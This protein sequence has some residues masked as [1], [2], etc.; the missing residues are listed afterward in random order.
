[1]AEQLALPA[2]DTAAQIAADVPRP[3]G[4]ADPVRQPLA[5]SAEAASIDYSLYSPE[6]LQRIA[7]EA[8]RSA[9]A[10]RRTRENLPKQFGENP[11]RQPSLHE[12]IIE[13]G[14]EER[15]KHLWDR[16]KQGYAGEMQK[17]V[18]AGSTDLK[19]NDA[20][21]THVGYT[22]MQAENVWRETRAEFLRNNAGT[23][24]EEE[25]R[26]AADRAADEAEA[27][28]RQARRREY[29]AKFV[30]PRSEAANGDQDDE[31]RPDA[32]RATAQVPERTSTEQQESGRDSA[33]K[34][35]E[36]RTEEIS[37]PSVAD[38]AKQL[39]EST[40]RQTVGNPR[41]QTVAEAATGGQ[42]GKGKF[43]K[44][45]LVKFLI[46]A[47]AGA[48]TRLALQGVEIL[49]IPFL[50]NV[51]GGLAGAAASI[52]VEASFGGWRRRDLGEQRETK[53]QLTRRFL[54]AGLRGFGAGLV[55]AL[56]IDGLDR[57][58][59]GDSVVSGAAIDP[60]AGLEPGDSA[61]EGGAD[62]PNIGKHDAGAESLLTPELKNQVATAMTTGDFTPLVGEG[63]L[64]AGVENPFAQAHGLAEQIGNAGQQ[65]QWA[66]MMQSLN[67]TDQQLVEMFHGDT[68]DKLQAAGVQIELAGDVNG[69]DITGDVY[70]VES[71][72]VPEGG[73]HIMGADG[74]LYSF[75]EGQMDR[76]TWSAAM[77]V[78]YQGGEIITPE[79]AAEHMA[80]QLAETLVNPE[81]KQNVT[82]AFSEYMSGYTADEQAVLV[83]DPSLQQG[84]ENFL[85]AQ[86]PEL[87]GNPEVQAYLENGGLKE[88]VGD[89]PAGQAANAAA[90][91]AEQF[92]AL[93]ESATS[94]LENYMETHKPEIPA[95][96]SLA[97]YSQVYADQ[98]LNYL[99]TLPEY[100]DLPVSG[101]G[102]DALRLE[103]A[104]QVR[105]EIVK[106][107][108]FAAVQ[109]RR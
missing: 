69:L 58:F 14:A 47:A 108:L 49:G 28:F 25:L 87:V 37:A 12:R 13:A 7:D 54:G 16:Y 15:N 71:M 40:A 18:D 35:E 77:H 11:L 8:A 41:A 23:A 67:Y 48:G 82:S 73:L 55:G 107:K 34:T 79:A 31:E 94:G 2:G 57:L 81:L 17:R 61:G 10:H 101:P 38:A 9:D 27:R 53:G 104:E 75:P 63:G 97:D 93:S 19:L 95:G 78:V 51:A 21:A 56:A 32:V 96:T 86:H 74:H 99:R 72:V 83:T 24:S 52:A 105:N 85:K 102:H 29:E 44:Q 62:G 36:P 92:S 43:I 68:L 1:M 4:E 98:Y 46:G 100:S 50:S 64:P 22:E 42:G 89:T 30:R 90:A 65:T 59:G 5:I 39:K 106:D 80:N 88:L 70:R 60:E 33:S 103:L 66:D 76:S 109:A 91:S 20:A 3:R 45:K 6:E 26:Q 84:F